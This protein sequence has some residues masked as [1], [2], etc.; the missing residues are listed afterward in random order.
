MATCSHLEGD[1]Q[2]KSCSTKQKLLHL[3]VPL[4]ICIPQ[5]FVSILKKG[6]ALPKLEDNQ[7]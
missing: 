2:V 3:S 6:D 5:N 7:S 1:L 4:K